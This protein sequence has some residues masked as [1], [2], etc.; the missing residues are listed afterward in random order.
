M[1]WQAPAAPRAQGGGSTRQG[2]PAFRP[3]AGWISRSAAPCLETSSRDRPR[4]LETS[5][6]RRSPGV[7]GDYAPVGDELRRVGIAAT[8][9]SSKIRH[10]SAL[11]VRFAVVIVVVIDAVLVVAITALPW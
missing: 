11:A 7:S 6:G 9:I 2:A 1:P 5:K 3:D 10:P 4:D 8:E